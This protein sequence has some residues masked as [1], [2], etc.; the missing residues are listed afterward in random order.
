MDGETAR[1]YPSDQQCKGLSWGVITPGYHF[2]FVCLFV[3]PLI[4]EGYAKFDFQ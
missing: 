2:L 3:F 4:Y 1:S